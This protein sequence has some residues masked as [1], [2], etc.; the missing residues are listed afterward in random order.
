MKTTFEFKDGHD[1]VIEDGMPVCSVDADVVVGCIDTDSVCL[2]DDVPLNL[3]SKIVF[4]N[5]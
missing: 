4:E 1:E 3:I 5:D 2:T